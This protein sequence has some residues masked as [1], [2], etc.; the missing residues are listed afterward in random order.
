MQQIS[1]FKWGEFVSVEVIDS[2]A[3]MIS[4]QYCSI[5]CDGFAFVFL[6]IVITNSIACKIYINN[7]N[8]TLQICKFL[9]ETPGKLYATQVAFLLRIPAALLEI[10][11]SDLML[12]TDSF[13]KFACGM[14][15][16]ISAYKLALTTRTQGDYHLELLRNYG[17][18]LSDIEIVGS[19]RY[20]S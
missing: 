5:V 3:L 13:V 20:L 11:T 12:C 7:Q 10:L 18:A 8:L 17:R 4:L 2:S 9:L 16:L 1:T 6:T 19:F 15:S 14:I